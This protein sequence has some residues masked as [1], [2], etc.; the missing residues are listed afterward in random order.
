MENLARKSSMVL[1]RLA[2]QFGP[3]CWREPFDSSSHGSSIKGPIANSISGYAD[4]FHR[5]SHW[6][7]LWQFNK[8]RNALPELR[9][10]FVHISGKTI[11]NLSCGIRI[12]LSQ[13]PEAE[14]WIVKRI[15]Q[16]A[17]VLDPLA[18]APAIFCKPR[19]REVALYDSSVNDFR[20]LDTAFKSQ[21]QTTREN[22]IEEAKS[23]SC[24]D[25]PFRRA[26]FCMVRV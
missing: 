20:S 21:H 10:I 16:F 1:V 15:D 26:I 5:F 22:R 4:G 8:L 25:Q 23:V 24:K 13:I 17:H 18:Q 14:F 7:F 12:F 2:S 3:K 9:E 11:S 6:Q 19:G